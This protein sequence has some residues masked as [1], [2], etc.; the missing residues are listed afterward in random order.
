MEFNENAN[1][2]DRQKKLIYDKELQPLKEKIS[3]ITLYDTKAA[4]EFLQDY[5]SIL[6]NENTPGYDIYGKIV[7][8]EFKMQSYME[9]DGKQKA[10]GEVSKAILQRIDDLKVNSIQLSLEEFKTK[11]AE[12]K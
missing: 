2:T 9:N 5:N 1:L 3:Q 6:E 10:F 8:L 11:F 4:L 7:D 12:I